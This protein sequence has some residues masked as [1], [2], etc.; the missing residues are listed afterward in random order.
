MK[1]GL[2][3]GWIRRRW[4]VPVLT[5][6]VATI[7]G[8]VVAANRP[9]SYTS[10]M[11]FLVPSTSG[12]GLSPDHAQKLAST[13]S[14]LLLADDLIAQAVGRAVNREPAD[15]KGRL[16]AVNPV[17]TA[18]VRVA[19]RGNTNAE[20]LAGVWALQAGLTGPKP[21]SPAIRPNSLLAV[22]EARV[23]G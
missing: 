12:R 16:S 22:Q 1:I 11:V 21:V 14:A 23:N 19:Y 5:V 15:V 2:R 7:I 20:A 3:A 10:T 18:L 8:G 13:Y 9:G 4:W 6:I 17:N